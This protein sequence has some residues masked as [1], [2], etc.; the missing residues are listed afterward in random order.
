MQATDE[1]SGTPLSQLS[2][3]AHNPSPPEP[4]QFVV[5]AGAAPAGVGGASGMIETVATVIPAMRAHMCRARYVPVDPL[6][7]PSSRSPF[8]DGTYEAPITDR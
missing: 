7:T 6:R 5:H 2:A 8:G 3:V 4:F 1:A